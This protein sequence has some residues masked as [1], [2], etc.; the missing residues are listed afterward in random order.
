MET[1]VVVAPPNLTDVK[2]TAIAIVKEA[3]SAIDQGQVKTVKIEVNSNG[4]CSLFVDSHDG[5]SRFIIE[6]QQNSGISLESK[7]D[8]SKPKSVEERRQRVAFLRKEHGMT[9]QEISEYTMTSQ[10]TVSNDIKK[11]R[12]QKILKE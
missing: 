4:N 6:R 10:K 12:E 11:L 8:V 3:V 7:A 9:Q 2:N 1:E 5:K